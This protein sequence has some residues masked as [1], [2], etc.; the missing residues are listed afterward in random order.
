MAALAAANHF[1]V[2]LLANGSTFAWGSDLLG[3]ASV[4]SPQAVC[5]GGVC[6][7]GVVASLSA[8]WEHAN[9]NP[10]PNPNSDPNPD[11]NPTPDPNTNLNPDPTP[12]PYP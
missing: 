10:N 12:N 5:G 7:G 11:P 1:S 4:P 6:G 2:A 9:P 8:G 3:A